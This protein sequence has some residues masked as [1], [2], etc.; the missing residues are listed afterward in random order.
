MVAELGCL[1]KGG[2]SVGGRLLKKAGVSGL[3]FFSAREE[4][5]CF[6]W[7]LFIYIFL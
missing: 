7:I 1:G 6:A 3:V 5:A 2:V 4:G